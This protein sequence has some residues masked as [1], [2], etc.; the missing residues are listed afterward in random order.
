[1][2]KISLGKL[3]ILLYGS[4]VYIWLAWANCDP[5]LFFVFCFLIIKQNNKGNTLTLSFLIWTG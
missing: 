1:V 3:Y 2:L 4:L 5:D